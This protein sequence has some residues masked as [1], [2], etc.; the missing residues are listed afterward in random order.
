MSL[1][2][3][4]APATPSPTPAAAP[5]AAV[6]KPTAA[7]PAGQPAASPEAKP[8]ASPAET[9]PAAAAPAAKP[10]QME[11]IHY[12]NFPTNPFHIVVT[13][14]PERGFFEKNGINLD[15]ITVSS[16]AAAA[17]AQEGG[18]MDLTTL[19]TDVSILNQ[20]KGSDITMVLGLASKPPY[21]LIVKPE[22]KTASELRGKTIGASSLKT[23]DGYIVRKI[24]EAQGLKEADYAIVVSG[25]QPNR[26]KALEAGAIDATVT[27]EPEVSILKDK[28]FRELARAVDAP[29]FQHYH[30]ISVAAKR[31][32]AKANEEK[33]VRFMMG[34]L[35]TIR[36]V[37]D[38]RN[39]AEVV[40]TLAAKMNIE[41][42]YALA[43]FTT[44]AE[45]LKIYPVDGGIDAEDVRGVMKTMAELGDITEPLPEPTRFYDLSYVEKARAR[46]GR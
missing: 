5:T 38:P 9:K 32:W 17:A 43:A 21:S 12:A 45:D 39:K 31:S 26:T 23:S 8:V 7:A 34:W 44:F 6:A 37:Y 36:W 22:F 25:T 11:T 46:L 2:G 10:A 30:T 15:L 20:A 29:A 27:I 14:G 35:E 19:A 4:C 40:R 33:L 41:E 42:K 16:G 24:L 3:A 13:V 1:F 28:G 18:S